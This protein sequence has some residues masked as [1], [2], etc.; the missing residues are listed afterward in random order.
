MLQSERL[1][2]RELDAS[3]DEAMFALDS[4]PEVHT[5]LGNNPLT[6]IEQSRAHI[7]NIRQQYQ[8]N[9]IGRMAVILK[10]TNEFIGWAGLKLESNVN[11]HDKFY[12]VGYRFMKKYWGNG[13]ATEA[14]LFFVNYGFNEL[15]LEKIN[16]CAM[17]GHIASRRA[18]EKSGLKFIEDFDYGDGE[19]C[20]WYEIN[21]PH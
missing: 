13:Y 1:C 20:A 11:G 6:D 12:D 5:Y 16:A 18:L 9:G 7:K 3:D 4:D 10:V 8:D 15:K 21:N 2:Y 17:V 14:A 19:I